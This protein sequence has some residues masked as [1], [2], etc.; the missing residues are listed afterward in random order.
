MNDLLTTPI[1]LSIYGMIKAGLIHAKRNCPMCLGRMLFNRDLIANADYRWTCSLCFYSLELTTSTPLNGIKLDEF[2]LFLRLWSESSALKI[3]QISSVLRTSHSKAHQKIYRFAMSHYW[4]RYIKPFLK[5]PGVVEID[6]TMSSARKYAVGT[7]FPHQRWI[8]GMYCRDTKICVMYNIR[9]RNHWNIYPLLKSHINPGGVVVSDEHATY[10]CLQSAK[11]R[12]ALFGW[13]HFWVVHSSGYSHEKFPFLFTS[14]I[15]ATWAKMKRQNTG[16]KQMNTKKQ[17]ESYAD[18]FCL[19]YI[20]K[21]DRVYQFA[22]KTIR[23]YFDDMVQKFK[24]LTN[25]EEQ[26]YPCAGA[27]EYYCDT[28]IREGNDKILK[29]FNSECY[30]DRQYLK[31][32][33]NYDSDQI[34]KSGCTDD[35]IDPTILQYV[36][37]EK[38][39][40]QKINQVKSLLLPICYDLAQDEEDDPEEQRRRDLITSETHKQIEISTVRSMTDLQYARDVQS[41]A[42]E[43]AICINYEKSKR[44]GFTMQKFL[45]TW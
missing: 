6:E 18:Q 3:T 4:A 44:P 5:L 20:L 7:K 38:Q 42:V 22:L 8:F 19:R 9:N 32:F 25:Y 12:L 13:Y 39:R 28:I 26:F 23:I 34:Q 43:N 17:I 41:A 31:L 15:E 33:K 10:V 30:Q 16:L 45:S 35:E 2:D 21:K 11:S 14:N 27:L 37:L 40:Y 1:I 36:E 24:T 29:V